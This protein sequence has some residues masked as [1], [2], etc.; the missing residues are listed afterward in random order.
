MTIKTP[1]LYNHNIMKRHYF[2]STMA[3]IA[4]LLLPAHASTININGKE[5]AIDTTADYQLG[6]GVQHTAFTLTIGTAKH[7]CYLLEIDLTNP[8]NTIEEYQSQSRMGATETLASAYQQLNAEQH[9][10]I[11][12]VN[13]NFWVVSSQ[14]TGTTKGMLGQP[15]SATARNG[16]LIGEPS[17]WNAGHGDRGVVMIDRQK[18][19]YIDNMNFAGTVCIASNDYAIRDVNRPRELPD[20]D[21]ITLFN[22]YLG[23]NPT[24]STDGIEIVFSTNE[25]NINGTM[26]CTVT[27][28]NR[29]GGTV[30]T[31]GTGVLQGRGTGAT[32]LSQ[33]NIGDTFTM[34]LGVISTNDENLHPDIMQM[35]T[36]NALILKDGVQT[37]RNTNEAYNNQN[38]PR[39]VLATNAARNKFWMM[40]AEKPGMFSA[41]MCAILQQCGA[42]EA[43]GLDG[44]GSAQMCIGGTV[45]NTTTDGAPRQVANSIWVF[46][47]APDDTVVTRIVPSATNIELP[48]YGTLQMQ[49]MAYNQY[50]VLLNKDLQGVQ[51]TCDPAAGYI[52][53]NGLFVCTGEGDITATYG[54]A[55]ATVHVT[56][57]QGTDISIRLD[58][59]LLSDD[60]NYA[61]EV[62]G[63]INSEKTPLQPK[64]L[65]WTTKDAT[66]CSVTQEG[67]I[68]G[69]SNGYC[70]VYGTLGN[71][72]DSLLVRVE[73]PEHKPLAWCTDFTSDK[74]QITGSNSAWNTQVVLQDDN[75]TAVT[76]H[77][78]G[79]RGANLKIKPATP[80]YSLPDYVEL[81]YEPADFPIQKINATLYANN[82]SK[83]YNYTSTSNTPDQANRL[84]INIDSLLGNPDDIAVYPVRLGY[85]S[86]L[87]D[88]NAE[89]KDYTMLLDGLYLHYGELS[90]GFNPATTPDWSIYPNPARDA[91]VICGAKQG[92]IAT[93]YN[94]QGQVV[95]Q[96]TL[97]GNNDILSIQTLSAGQYLLKIN[98]TTTKLIKR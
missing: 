41:D 82:S 8:Y 63:I 64:A 2:L 84:V 16:V 10:T 68:N 7:N 24:R 57:K 95:A 11:A 50:G 5:C 93:L 35:V 59:V 96:T 72:T 1:Y 74:M 25:W 90:L 60:T 56:V 14:N 79:G 88:V 97:Q 94:L 36:G 53:N 52:D 66:V 75:K 91:L 21:E 13:C 37:A 51:L 65:S 73:I 46:S 28:V 32:A 30:I 22:H 98:N 69:V 26:T 33:L 61:V 86:F 85:I 76:I 70:W 44:G 55:Q 58:S 77:F 29:T 42:T 81:R 3:C 39:T 12:G 31:S 43:A 92:D 45:I 19:V 67:V 27:A 47:T 9:R 34:S 38:Y 89:Q 83:L 23:T 4:T 18:K 17:D 78:T 6:P 40:V 54:N 20:Q 80:L 71:K 15:F 49:F 62:Y 87:L 48:F